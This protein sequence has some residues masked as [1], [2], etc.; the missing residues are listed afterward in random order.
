MISTN[1][2]E[3]LDPNSSMSSYNIQ[4]IAYMLA[5]LPPFTQ[6]RY[7]PRVHMLPGPAV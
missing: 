6:L 7:V 5:G 3:V 2:V 1:I 4:Q